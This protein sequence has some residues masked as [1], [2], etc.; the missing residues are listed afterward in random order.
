MPRHT[1]TNV[2]KRAW[3]I[4]EREAGEVNPSGWTNPA[5]IWLETFGLV[6]PQ[7]LFELQGGTPSE[8]FEVALVQ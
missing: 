3:D 2:E 5:G 8:T 6:F 1:T 4:A 7:S